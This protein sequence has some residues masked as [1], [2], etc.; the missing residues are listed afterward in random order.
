MNVPT[1]DFSALTT[2]A[3]CDKALAPARRIQSRLEKNE[4][5][6]GFNESEGNIRTSQAQQQYARADRNLQSVTAE[7]ADLPAGPSTE[8]DQLEAEQA[9]LVARKK[10]L[11]LQGASGDESS[12]QDL[13]EAR[14][15]ADL[16]MVTGYIGQLETHRLGLP[17]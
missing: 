10:N 12:L 5:V 4:A 17:A 6:L 13:A 8:R 11:A 2:R 7:L 15:D 3:A 14:N 1:F 16:E 9:T